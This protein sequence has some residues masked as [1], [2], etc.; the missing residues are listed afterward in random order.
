MSLTEFLASFTFRHPAL[1]LLLFI[2]PAYLL[3]Y[4][5][6]FSPRRLS[7]SLSYNPNKLK[8]QGIGFSWLRFVPLAMQC[9][10][11]TLLFLAL[12]RPQTSFTVVNRNTEGIDIMLLMD[13]SSSMDNPFLDPNYEP[14]NSGKKKPDRLDAAKRTAKK[15]I[16]GREDDRIGIV[17]FAEDAYSY[18]P[19]TL[20]YELLKEQIDEIDSGDM[21]NSKTAMGSAIMIGILRMEES[22]SPSKV[23]ILLTDGVNTAGEIKPVP[24]SR[25]AAENGIKIYSIGIG[26]RKFMDP[27]SLGKL[28]TYSA[29]D[30]TTLKEISDITQGRYF[31]AGDPQALEKV[32]NQISELE[33][34]KVEVQQQRLV[35]DLYP[36]LLI[37]ALLCL[38]V[39][40]G[41][42]AF[43][44]YNPLEE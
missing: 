10:A 20:D 39:A 17:L 14:D 25:L 24:A 31:H 16:D 4:V 34:S 18:S 1:L 26:E 42:M 12:A 15:F 35:N 19:R 5:S 11:L 30:E 40:F 28:P 8:K 2:V 43:M 13:T 7:I 29:F 3:W 23:M 33:K 38:V 27:T 6:W 9:I 21:P 41:F 36:P 44:L 32:F 22:E 37:I